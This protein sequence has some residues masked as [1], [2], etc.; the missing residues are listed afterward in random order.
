MV[1]LQTAVVAVTGGGCASCR[2]TRRLRRRPNSP[3]PHS[4][5]PAP[6]AIGATTSAPAMVASPNVL[7]MFFNFDPLAKARRQGTPRDDADE[8]SG[9]QA[10][11]MGRARLGRAT[12]AGEAQIRPAGH[13]APAAA[14]AVVAC[15]SPCS[16]AGSWF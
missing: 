14:K 9:F 16:H 8:M 12:T 5:L 13:Y 6:S 4:R 10:A 3:R 7:R 1:K 15:R 2:P 11:G